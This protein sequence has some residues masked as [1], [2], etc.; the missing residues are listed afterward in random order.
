[1]RFSLQT[2]DKNLTQRRHAVALAQVEAQFAMFRKGVVGLS[3]KQLVALSGEVYRFYIDTFEE[4]P[5]SPEEWASFKAF[6]RATVEG[7]LVTAPAITPTTRPNVEEA[8]S[9]FGYDL[10]AGVNNLTQA[11][12]KPPL[13]ARF[14][15]LVDWVLSREGLL[16]DLETREKLLALVETAS[17]DAAWQLKRNASGDYTPDPKALRFP[18]LNQKASLSLDH[19]VDR[20]RKETAPSASTVSSWKKPLAKAKEHFG[21]KAH[22]VS[23]I[24]AEDVVAWKDALL[25]S[26]EIASRTI[27][28]TY[29]GALNA[30]LNFAERNRLIET[31]PAKNIRISL[32]RSNDNKRLPYTDEEVAKLIALSATDERPWARWLPSLLA[33][34]GARI[35]ELTQL[36][37]ERVTEIDGIK[38]IQIDAA[39]DGGNLKNSWA[40]RTVPLHPF[41]VE[42][43]FWDWAKSQPAGPLFYRKSSR[44]KKGKHTSLGTNNRF[45][46]W[47]RSNGFEEE[48]K[49]PAHSFRH[50]FKSV[51]TRYNIQDSIA[52]AIQGHA[53]SSIAGSYRHIDLNMMYEAIERI[54]IPRDT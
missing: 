23:T 6:N 22:N 30:W 46:E 38:C 36:F 13:E 21:T 31:N 2:A 28:S 47:V 32:K 44:P 8:H 4:N 39:E 11:S 43:G 37:S 14:G 33:C 15:Q 53:D 27:N 3:Q 18:K 48:R 1:M 29:L 5:G 25:D 17:T 16:I 42:N 45:R 24:R 26:R 51:A 35:G 41:L 12:H 50:W 52:D 9:T 7:R 19:I 20:W 34:T 40:K 49:A 54:P 10:T